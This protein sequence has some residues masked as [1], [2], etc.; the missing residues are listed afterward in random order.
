MS[1]VAKPQRLDP[2]ARQIAKDY[3]AAC[4]NPCVKLVIGTAQLGRTHGED[5]AMRNGP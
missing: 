3:F 1:V 2:W 5:D 4:L